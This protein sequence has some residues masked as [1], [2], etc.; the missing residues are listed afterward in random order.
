MNANEVLFNILERIGQWM[1]E[2]GIN[3]DD[4]PQVPVFLFPFEPESEGVQVQ[5]PVK[6]EPAS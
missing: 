3:G 1:E 6:L 4:L 2:Q 5:V